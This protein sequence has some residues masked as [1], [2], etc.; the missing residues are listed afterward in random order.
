MTRIRSRFAADAGASAVSFIVAFVVVV[1][2]AVAAYFSV[3]SVR[4]RM[5]SAE[6]LDEATALIKSADATVLDVDAIVR[7]QVTPELGP[8]AKAAAEK[9]PDAQKALLEAIELLEESR[10][11]LN[12][13]EQERADVLKEAAEARVDMLEVAGPILEANVKAAAALPLANEAWDSVLEA[14]KKI[15]RAVKEYNRLNKEGVT[16]SRTLNTQALQHLRTAKAKF[17]AVRKA[18]PEAKIDVY[19]R[20]IDAK[21]RLVDLS[22]QSDDA[23]LKKD[24]A[25]ANELAG[26]YNAEEK[27]VLALG[28]K[29][30]AGPAAIVADAYDASAQDNV[31]AYFLARNKAARADEALRK[32]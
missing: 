12:D 14:E 6:Q 7:A 13:D 29:L 23:W 4:T 19:I 28:K 8:K 22:R 31:T 26:T 17:Q 18:F 16:Q 27:K 32:L 10:D 1:A 5:A 11:G 2:I 9:I 15:D 21:S 25:K 20:Y 30:P 3:Q 24:V